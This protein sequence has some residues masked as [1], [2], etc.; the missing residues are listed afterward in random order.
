[1]GCQAGKPMIP[2]YGEQVTIFK[3]PDVARKDTFFYIQI[4]KVVPALSQIQDRMEK[5]CEKEPR[6]TP[7]LV[8]YLLHMQ[9]E[10]ISHSQNPQNV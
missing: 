8:K 6:K 3:G 2:R 10:L 4:S 1:M 5:N 7:K 9:E